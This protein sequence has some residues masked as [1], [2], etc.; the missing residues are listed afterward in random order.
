MTTR[1]T[2]RYFVLD[3]QVFCP[4]QLTEIDVTT[5]A[6]CDQLRAVDNEAGRPSIICVPP[7]RDTTAG[8]LEALLR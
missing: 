8:R 7:P 6:T 5:C 4:R 3:G 1:E 2:W